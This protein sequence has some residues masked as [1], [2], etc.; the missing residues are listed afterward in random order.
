MADIGGQHLHQKESR[1]GT[2]TKA[3][4]QHSERQRLMRRNVVRYAVLAYVITL[5]RVSLRVKK[6]FP[7]WQHVVDSGDN[8]TP[9]N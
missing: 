7:T 8:S 5:Q 9:W 1:E 4:L 6:R 2:H 3:F